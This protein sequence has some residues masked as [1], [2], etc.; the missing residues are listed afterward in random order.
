MAH[1]WRCRAP[2]ACSLAGVAGLVLA[3]APP[4]QAQGMGGQP[5]GSV[6][7]RLQDEQQRQRLDRLQDQLRQPQ[8]PLIEG[9]P[10]G[11]D[12]D[13]ERPAEPPSDGLPPIEVIELEGAALPALPAWQAL[14]Q[15]FL[16]EPATPANLARLRQEVVQALAQ[17]DLLAEVGQP[18]LQPD[19]LVQVPVLV[20]RLGAVHVADNQAPIP[21]GWAVATVLDAVGLGREMRLDKLES[22][23][24]KLN[25]LGGVRAS[26]R[27]EPGEEPGRTD[28]WLT[29]ASTRQVLADVALNNHT[30][31]Y[32]GPYQ[33]EV[34]AELNGLLGRGEQVLLS[35]TYSGDPFTWGSRSAG[36][37]LE[38]PL[39]PGG[40][41]GV[42][43]VNWSDYRLLDE[44]QSDDYTG[45][46][47]GGGVGLR[48]VLWRRPTRNLY[49]Q[50]LADTNRSRDSVLGFEYSDRTSWAGRFSLE[51]DY[52]DDWMGIGLNS[53]ILTLSLGS[54][55]L[56]GALDRPDLADK[57][58]PW[59]KLN[60]LFSRYQ[61]F[62]E[63]PWSLEF[64]AQGQ[65]A[66]SNLDSVEKMSLGWP[67]GVR[68]YPPGEAAGD[69]GVALQG[70]VRYQLARNLTAK[71]FVDGGYIWRW[72][73]PFAGSLNP[74]AFGLW[75]PGLGLE[76]G[77]RGDVL[78]SVD[79][80]W[81]LGS[82]RNTPSG[83]DVDGTNAD[84]RVW[85]S[86]RKWL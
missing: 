26:A 21:S 8:A 54:L 22:A 46:F 67:N 17:A 60:L 42:A 34:A 43:A 79:V 16:G 49:V 74:N 51:G 25:D 11:E 31:K 39:T 72:T 73:D 10:D 80:A 41:S 35:G 55:S 29:L 2:L 37:A 77:T 66:F 85:V 12:G 5:S 9:R 50:A 81:P 1:P 13:G 62:P 59:G 56:D 48:H 52:Q 82:N 4:L 3:V 44:F 78:A 86:V 69:S 70:T 53:G 18:V 30:T 65:V 61:L 84:V 23:L 15:R 6:E 58:G 36:L 63:S 7:R 75:G 20:A 28:V 24:L 14:Q 40:L 68:A 45:S 76:W 27:L 38:W 19:G 83:V 47:L 71:A 32:T 64:F 33:P 57:G